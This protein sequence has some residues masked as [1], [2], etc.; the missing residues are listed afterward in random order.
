MNQ[1]FALNNSKSWYAVKTLN[2]SSI[3]C[4]YPEWYV[5]RIK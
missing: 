5:R 3:E 2:W 4:V 1:I